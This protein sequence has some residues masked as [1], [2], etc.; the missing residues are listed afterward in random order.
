[1]TQHS[2]K[3]SLGGLS[4]EEFSEMVIRLAHEIR[5]PLSTIKTAVQL[6][7]HLSQPHS[8][9]AEYYDSI[10]SQVG[11]IDQTINDMQRFARLTASHP[12]DLQLAKIVDEAV[13][14]H[15]NEARAAGISLVV[16]GGPPV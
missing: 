15:R 9:F 14:R 6:I 8:Q 2:P 10:I 7:Q 4:E 12:V 13:W 11:R 1:M 16:V 5:N 3:P